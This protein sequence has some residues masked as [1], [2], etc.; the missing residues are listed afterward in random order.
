MTPGKKTSW[1]HVST[2]RLMLLSIVLLII[3][4]VVAGGALV[5]AGGGGW[6][7]EILLVDLPYLVLGTIFCALYLAKPM[8]RAAAKSACVTSL[9]I[10]LLTAVTYGGVS[11]SSTGGL[12]FFFAPWWFLLGGPILFAVCLAIV[13]V[14]SRSVKSDG[15]PRCRKCGY[16]LVGL[17]D[18]R[19]PECGTGFDLEELKSAPDETELQP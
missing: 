8:R 13:L 16:L 9:I 17:R 5:S 12:V 11:G 19:C 7:E 1:V 2:A 10:L 15:L 6:T 18:P 3:S 14:R 4:A